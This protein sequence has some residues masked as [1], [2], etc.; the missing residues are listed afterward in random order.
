MK[1]QNKYVFRTIISE[2]SYFFK[3][4]HESGMIFKPRLL[5]HALLQIQ[6]FQVNIWLLLTH[7][8]K[9]NNIIKIFLILLILYFYF[10]KKLILPRCVTPT[11]KLANINTRDRKHFES[12]PSRYVIIWCKNGG[13]SCPTGDKMVIYRISSCVQEVDFGPFDSQPTSWGLA[14]RF[15]FFWG[16]NKI[17]NNTNIK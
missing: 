10:F 9:F 6:G 8:I 14:S 15:L 7:L 12:A 1:I 2:F 11:N 16:I 13:G 17:F 3:K 4:I 5:G